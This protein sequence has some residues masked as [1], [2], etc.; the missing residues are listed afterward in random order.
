MVTQARNKLRA[1]RSPQSHILVRAARATRINR[2]AV[3][4]RR[5]TIATFGFLNTYS[6]A[7][8]GTGQKETK[9]ASRIHI[10]ECSFSVG[11]YRKTQI[12]QR[13]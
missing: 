8:S 5:T 7:L 1:G 13:T 2:R 9:G 4:V 10:I 11:Y 12:K 3:A 6:T